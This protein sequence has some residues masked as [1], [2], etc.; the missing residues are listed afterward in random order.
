M[1]H[2]LFFC[3]SLYPLLLGQADSLRRTYTCTSTALS[4][5]IG[6]DRILL[7]LRN[8]LNGALTLTSTAS[9]TVVT[10]YICHNR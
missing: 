1:K 9:D 10:N 7:T 6:I 2:P 5:Q 3:S 4:A 8:C